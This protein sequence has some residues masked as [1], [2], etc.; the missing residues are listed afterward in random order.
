MAALGYV[1]A[2]NDG[3]RGCSQDVAATVGEIAEGLL[4]KAN[5]DGV[6]ALEC[7]EV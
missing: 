3:E 1:N 4:Y 5:A 6:A 2:A 7:M